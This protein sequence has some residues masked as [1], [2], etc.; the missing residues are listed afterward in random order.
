[1]RLLHTMLRVG[2][3]QRSIDFYTQV[4]GMKLLRTTERPEQKYSLAFVGYGSNPEHAEIELTYNHGVDSYELGSAFGHIA[5]AVPDA[6]S[7]WQRAQLRLYCFQPLYTACETVSRGAR[8]YSSRS[9]ASAA[10]VVAFDVSCPPGAAAGSAGAAA[11][12][13]GWGCCACTVSAAAAGFG[14]CAGAAACLVPLSVDAVGRLVTV[15]VGGAA[16]AG[17]A[18]GV[19][20][21]F[22]DVS[23]A[24]E[25]VLSAMAGAAVSVMGIAAESVFTTDARVVSMPAARFRSPPQAAASARARKA[26]LPA[27]RR[28]GYRTASSCCSEAMKPSFRFRR[29]PGAGIRLGANPHQNE[30]R[31]QIDR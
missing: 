22:V 13:V 23:V 5:I 31:V 26:A 14:R 2:N 4:L 8:W 18:A 10:A 24:A 27:H 20:S 29:G 25:P 11:V 1:M 28:A 12:G 3:L 17:A 9:G 7:P 30:D 6:S 15:G 16:F 19:V 21:G